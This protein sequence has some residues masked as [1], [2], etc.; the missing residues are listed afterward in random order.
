MRG[1]RNLSRLDQGP[2]IALIEVPT[3]VATLHSA[4]GQGNHKADNDFSASW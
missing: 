3:D 1:V 4:A 2:L